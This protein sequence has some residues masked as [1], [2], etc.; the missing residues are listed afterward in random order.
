MALTE[1]LELRRG[2]QSY[3]RSAMRAPLLDAQHE[4]DLARLWRAINKTECPHELGI[5]PLFHGTGTRRSVHYGAGEDRVTLTAWWGMYEL[6]GE[7]A[8]LDFALDG[9]I[10]MDTSKGFGF[11]EATP[12]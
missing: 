3:L 11:V 10:G 2:A 9:G 6:T 5:R 12:S 4:R 7:P 1:T 8:F